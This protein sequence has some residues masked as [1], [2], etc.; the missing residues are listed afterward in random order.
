MSW[1]HAQHFCRNRR[2]APHFQVQVRC[3]LFHR[4]LRNFHH[5]HQHFLLQKTTTAWL[6]QKSVL[7]CQRPRNFR[8]LHQHLLRQKNTSAWLHRKRVLFLR[9]L[10]NFHR[11]HQQLLRQTLHRKNNPRAVVIAHQCRLHSSVDFI[12]SLGL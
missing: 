10:R 4:P 5:L 6:H 1:N 8:R 11:L 3:L 2:Q 7:F 9:R 12:Y